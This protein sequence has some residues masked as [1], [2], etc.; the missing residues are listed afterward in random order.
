MPNH[1]SVNLIG[2]L[3]RDPESRV[4]GADTVVS[5]SVATTLKR[6]AG[7]ITTWWECSAWGKTGEIASR[8]LHRGDAVFVQGE[9]SMQEYTARDGTPQKKMAVSVRAIAL[10]GG[11][12]ERDAAEAPAPRPPVSSKDF[13]RPPYNGP[14]PDDDIPF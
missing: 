13:Q 6:R 9:P 11:K 2:H 12:R 10:L 5:F 1:A 14:Y 8:Y 7:D 3:G 4:V